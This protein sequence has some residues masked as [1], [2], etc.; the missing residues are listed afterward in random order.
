MHRTIGLHSVS[1]NPTPQ[2]ALVVERAV[3]VIQ[4]WLLSEGKGH[5]FESCRVRHKINNLTT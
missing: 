3:P 5:T 4:R 2:E 1:G